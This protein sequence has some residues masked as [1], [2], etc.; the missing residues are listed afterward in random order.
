[1][2]VVVPFYWGTGMDMQTFCYMVFGLVGLGTIIHSSVDFM[3]SLVTWKVLSKNSSIA[4]ISNV[5]NVYLI[6]NA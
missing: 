6:K 1:M 4:N 2:I 3:I 5:K